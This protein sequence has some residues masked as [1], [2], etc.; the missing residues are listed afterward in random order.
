METMLGVSFVL[1]FIIFY[2]FMFSF[3]AV[4]VF[5]INETIVYNDIDNSIQL[6]SLENLITQL[7]IE[8]NA[9]NRRIIS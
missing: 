9:R 6:M 4:A 3:F 5:L 8:L 1:Y 2:F 7:P